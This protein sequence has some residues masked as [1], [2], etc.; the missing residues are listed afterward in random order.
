MAKRLLVAIL[1]IPVGLF[2]IYL[3]G[4]IY[5]IFITAVLGTA[6]WEY[7]KLFKASGFNAS[8]VLLL[9]G[10]VLIAFNALAHSFFEF[11]EIELILA[12]LTL[13]AM[14]YHLVDYERGRDNA[15][16][17][18]A[19]TLGGLLYLGLIGSYLISIRFIPDGKWWLLLVLPSVMFAD[20]GAY[21]IGSRYG[22]HKLSPRLSPHKTWE[23]YIAGVV[24]GTASGILLGA[25]WH[26]AAPVVTIGYGAIIGFVM[27][28]VTPL[29]DLGE[30]MLKRQAGAKDSSHII[31][32]HGGILDRIDSWLWA[33]IIGYYVILFFL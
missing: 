2:I 13:A 31:P 22:R 11:N 29:G 9:G 27:S 17:D 5:G 20:S 26:V 19:I 3:G 24:F 33:A 25:I 21:I 12:L 18:F 14:A 6:A 1:L 32:G 28:V 30:S 8:L 16:T 23:G 15:A 4:W 10:V 7:W